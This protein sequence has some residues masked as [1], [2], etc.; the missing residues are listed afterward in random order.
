MSKKNKNKKQALQLPSKLPQRE[1]LN[2]LTAFAI[3]VQT[4]QNQISQ[5]DTADVNLRRYMITLNRYLLSALYVEIGIIQ[6][7]IDQ[8]VDDAF[9]KLPELKSSQL[10]PEE[11]EAVKQYIQEKGWFETFKQ[12]VKWQR[13]FGGAGL[14]IHVPQNPLAQLQLS[15]INENTPIELYA[16]NRW[17]LNY[18]ATGQEKDQTVNKAPYYIE[19]VQVHESKVLKFTGKEA[20]DILRLQLQ[21]WGMSEVERLLRS[22][23]SYL[24]NQDVIFELLDEAKID[25]YQLFGFREAV[26]GGQETE[27]IKQVSAMNSIKNYLNA[28]VMDSEDKFETKNMTFTGLSEMLT[29]IRQGIA[30]DLKMPVTKLWGVS[31]AGFNSGEDD[32]EN[33]NSML[34]SE[35]RIKLRQNLIML[36]KLACQAVH[37]FIPEDIDIEYPALRVLSAEQEENVKKEQFARLLQSH[38]A[39]LITDEQFLD[40][41]NKA[42]LLPIEIDYNASAIKKL[43]DSKVEMPVKGEK[44]K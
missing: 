28:V 23:N 31:A 30:A 27:V 19:N 9:A 5:S 25:V 18:Q 38:Q 39:Q 20:P 29:Q 14:Y 7:L 8:P 44:K 12:A 34:E 15:R 11:I 21:G 1:K 43:K 16:Y 22:L 35:M 42:N 36:Y 40:V 41:C 32:I 37:G 33:Y 26:M 3:G 13:L 2:D 24:K 6:T 4:Q 17:E 10:Q